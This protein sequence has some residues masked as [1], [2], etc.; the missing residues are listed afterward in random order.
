MSISCNLCGKSGFKTLEDDQQPYSV[1]QC[2][3]CALVFVHPQPGPAELKNHYDNG[4]YKEW[5]DQQKHR[6][7]RMWERRVKQIIRVRETGHLL[8][9]GSGEGTFLTL[10]QKEGW[11]VSG[12]EFSEFAAKH[13]ADALKTD[14][15]C[16]ELPDA[17]FLENSFDVVT[18]WHV[19]EH[20]GDPKKYL[21]EIHRILKPNGLFVLAVPNVN[22]LVFQL[23]YRIVRG[24]KLKLFTMG[25]KEIHLYHFS[26]KTI[27]DF[28]MRAGF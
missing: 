24:H 6:R 14:I 4:Y 27:K 20:V 2:T 3:N 22:N 10:V 7:I 1:L 28:L 17:D 16:G 5:L 26:P 18:M 13:A 21:E 15:F 11:Q 19:L 9:V 25:E 23:A 12:T 8:D